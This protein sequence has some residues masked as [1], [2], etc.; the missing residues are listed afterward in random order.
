MKRIILALACVGLA[1]GVASADRFHG[2]RGGGS[3]HNGGSVTVR[4]HRGGGEWHGAREGG[5]RVTEGARWNNR[6]VYHGGYEN[7]GYG[8]RGYYNGGY[9]YSNVVRRPIYVERPYIRERYYD[10][11]YR[12]SL[13]V[14]NY[15]VRDGYYWVAGQ[16]TWDGYEWQ[17]QPGHY[18]PDPNWGVSAGVGV[19]VD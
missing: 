7:R 12:P 16:W 14:E 3:F 6:P 8:N 13:I 9:R 2:S 5:V 11:R 4:D 17:W 1:G 18:E 19:Y 10:Y 15:P